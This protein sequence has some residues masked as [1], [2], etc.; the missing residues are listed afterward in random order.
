MKNNYKH[1]QFNSIGEFVL[2]YGQVFKVDK[3]I[4]GT[5]KQCFK[6]AALYAIINNCIYVEGYIYCHIPILHAWVIDNNKI[7][8]VTLEEP[9]EEY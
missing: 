3:C 9:A 7:I 8:E 1:R 6:N 4:K 2:E 5:P